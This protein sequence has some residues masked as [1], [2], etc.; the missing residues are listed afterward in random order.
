MSESRIVVA[1][2]EQRAGGKWSR[3]TQLGRFLLS[4]VTTCGR[5][6]LGREQVGP[7]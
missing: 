2:I 5:A 6:Q 1:W 4:S 7:A 3:M